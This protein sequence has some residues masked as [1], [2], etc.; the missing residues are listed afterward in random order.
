MSTYLATLN[1]PSRSDVTAISD[2][3]Q[4]IETYMSRIANAL[5]AQQPPVPAKRARSL[6]KPVKPRRTKRP[7]GETTPS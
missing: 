7:P 5:E 6:P 1:L 3:L 4:T 2:R